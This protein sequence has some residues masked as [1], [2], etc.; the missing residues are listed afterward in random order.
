MI[1]IKANTG[2]DSNLKPLYGLPYKH[3]HISGSKFI[4][5]REEVHQDWDDI[6]CNFRELH[7]DGVESADEQLPVPA[8]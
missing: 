6:C 4:V 1:N 7:A 8:E 5:V 2:L 3:Q